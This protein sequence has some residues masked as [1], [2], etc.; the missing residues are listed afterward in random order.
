MTSV[1]YVN[2]KLTHVHLVNCGA[3]TGCFGRIATALYKADDSEMNEEVQILM[4]PNAN[5]IQDKGIVC[6]CG[7]CAAPAFYNQL[8]GIFIPGCPPT[9]QPLLDH[10]E[11]LKAKI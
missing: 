9:I 10:L 6:L 11:K 2:K 5:S 8:E 1:D 7:D 4:G 3:C